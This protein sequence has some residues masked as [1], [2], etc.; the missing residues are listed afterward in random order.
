MDWQR[1]LISEYNV[2]R[3]EDDELCAKHHDEKELDYFARI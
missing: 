3:Q 2:I 1:I